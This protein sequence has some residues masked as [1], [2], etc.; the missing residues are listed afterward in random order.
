MR[1]VP[2]SLLLSRGCNWDMI[3]KLTELRRVLCRIAMLA[4]VVV[5]ILEVVTGQGVLSGRLD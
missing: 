2:A 5:L 4:I 3:T 1:A